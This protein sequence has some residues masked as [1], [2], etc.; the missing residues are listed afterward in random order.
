M[1][2]TLFLAGIC[3]AAAAAF[4]QTPALTGSMFH[5]YEIKPQ[6]RLVLNSGSLTFDTDAATVSGSVSGLRSTNGVLGISQSTNV[7]LAVFCFNKIDLGS[8]VAVTV[9]GRRGLVLLS[10]S[11]L[12]LD[13]TI[14]VSATEP[15]PSD[16]Y[17]PGRGG[18]GAEGG[19]N[20]VG[21]NSA[22]PPSDGGDGG[23]GG[24]DGK[25]NTAGVGYGA[26]PHVGKTS[27]G[28]GGGY[29]GAG[30]AGSG[31][32]GVDYGMSSLED[33]LGGSGGAGGHGGGHPSALGA[34]GG[35][36]A[37]EL[38]SAQNIVLGPE[39]EILA[40]G[41]DGFGGSEVGSG[42]GS[43][44]GILLAAQRIICAAGA[45][46]SAQGGDGAIVPPRKGAGGGGGGR[47]AFY[48]KDDYGAPGE[49]DETGL[50]AYV[51]VSGGTGRNNGQDG[52]FYDGP[53][54]PVRPP[55]LVMIVF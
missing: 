30:G 2:Y 32:G 24:R 45:T 28:G 33:L 22:P 44:G 48:S 51:T 52:S 26:A 6:G 1:R 19:T 12:C 35:G 29:G 21:F 53:D 49:G 41:S 42:G 9:Q 55:G 11:D 10:R 46:V 39:A 54:S 36:G 8:N 37:V 13:T 16:R 17:I 23:P 5:P 20:G 18:P 15:D 25:P 14:D 3:S 38:V 40:D 50:P 31:A 34:G 43:G 4:A 27:D 47:I 7:E